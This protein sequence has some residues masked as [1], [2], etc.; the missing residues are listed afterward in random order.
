MRNAKSVFV[1]AFSL[2]VAS[3]SA[4]AAYAELPTGF[5][6]QKT[7]IETGREGHPKS[8]ETL[9][10]AQKDEG[11]SAMEAKERAELEAK[12]KKAKDDAEKKMKEPKQQ[13]QW[14]KNM[15]EQMDKAQQG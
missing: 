14:R 1:A 7:V 15:K 8:V 2:S 6:E 10:M 5:A 13:E 9:R 12:G 11:L 4:A 3:M